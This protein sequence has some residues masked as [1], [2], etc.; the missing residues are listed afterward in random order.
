MGMV[1]LMLEWS[2]KALKYVGYTF[3]PVSSI[4]TGEWYVDLMK[5][6]KG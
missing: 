2:A 5:R 3:F 6:K 4:M 1:G